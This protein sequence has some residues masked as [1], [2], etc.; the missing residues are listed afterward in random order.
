MEAQRLKTLW[1]SF[2]ESK[3][4]A[5]AQPASLLVNQTDDPTTLFTTAGMQQFV[6][7]LMGKEHPLGKRLFNIQ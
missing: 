7:Y 6:P 4:H 5:R 3:G 2:W 1:K